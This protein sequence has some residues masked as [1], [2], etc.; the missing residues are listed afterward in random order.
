MHGNKRK[1]LREQ[2]LKVVEI[3]AQ[4]GRQSV[5]HAYILLK[6]RHPNMRRK[7]AFP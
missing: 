5:A 4:P 3:V 1:A 7:A 6:S 2:G